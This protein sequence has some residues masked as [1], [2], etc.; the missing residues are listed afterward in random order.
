MD[1][2][3]P[4]RGLG[5]RAVFWEGVKGR[6][7]NRPY[8]LAPSSRRRHVPLLGGLA[9]AVDAFEFDAKAPQPRHVFEHLLS[10]V[11]QRPV[12]VLGVAQ[13]ERAVAAQVDVPDLDVGLA[14]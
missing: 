1:A 11:V 4:F 8:L 3:W 9:A 12:Q 2:G 7:P 14:G 10:A 5:G 13:G 6:R